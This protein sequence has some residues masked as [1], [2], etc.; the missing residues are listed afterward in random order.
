[1]ARDDVVGVGVAFS[2]ALPS[3]EGHVGDDDVRHAVCLQHI[4]IEPRECV[5]AR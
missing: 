5:E 1:L 4:T 3:R 2:R